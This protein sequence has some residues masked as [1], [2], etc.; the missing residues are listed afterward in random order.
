METKDICVLL[1]CSRMN[2]ECPN[3]NCEIVRKF[4]ST[5]IQQ[6]LSGSAKTVSPKCPADTSDNDERCSQSEF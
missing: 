2:K 6:S 5:F 4:T 3:D 1:G